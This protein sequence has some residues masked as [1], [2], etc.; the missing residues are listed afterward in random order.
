MEDFT[1]FI[2]G[3]RRWRFPRANPAAVFGTPAKSVVFA[4]EK[5]ASQQ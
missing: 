2:G 1:L 3:K 5:H 4:S